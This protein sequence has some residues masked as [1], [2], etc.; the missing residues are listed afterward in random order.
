MKT[1]KNIFIPLLILVVMSAT[2]SNCGNDDLISNPAGANDQLS[3]AAEFFPLNQ[4]YYTSYEITKS[5]GS[6]EIQSFKVGGEVEFYGSTAIEWF[7][8][9]NNRTD[10][11]FF[12]LTDET[13]IYYPS[14]NSSPEK[15]VQLPFAVGKSWDRTDVIIIDETNVDS[16]DISGTKEDTTNTI[17]ITAKQLPIDGS[18][19]MT[20]EA[21]ESIVLA[22]GTFYSGAYRVQT[23]S[24][25]TTSNYYWYVSDIGLVKYLLDAT[26]GD[27]ESGRE[28][29]ELVAFGIRKY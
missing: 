12:Q 10:T 11:G 9:D 5:D 29:G 19:T 26:N 2:L 4:N 7:S 15:I 22:N 23:S 1:R 25:S 27:Y 3:P 17:I 14:R 21:R 28:K 24:T 16:T 20:I 13:V 18:S 6:V 8:Y